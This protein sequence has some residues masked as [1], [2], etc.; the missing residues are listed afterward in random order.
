MK[1]MLFITAF[2]PNRRTAGQNYSKE[3]LSSLENNFEI[4]LISFSYPNH[5]IE[6]SSKINILKHYNVSKFSKLLSCFKIPLIHP[7]FATRFRY[8]LLV[9]I[10]KNKGSYNLIYFDFSQVFLYSL[11]LKNPFKIM[12]S[13]DVIYQ[14]MKRNKWFKLNPFN[15]LLYS[16]EKK[17]LRTGDLILTF[18]KKDKLLLTDLYDIRSDVVSFFIDEKIKQLK[19]DAL[20]FERKFC[21]FGAWN[22][23]ENKEGLIWFM[24]NVLPFVDATIK[25]EIIGPG[26][27]DIVMQKYKDY[28]IEYVG[29]IENPY[30]KIAESLA[31]IAPVFKGAGVKVKVIESLA[32]GTTVIGTNVAFEGIDDLGDGSMILCSAADDYIK[33][34][35][36]FS[37]DVR[38]KKI[39]TKSLFNIAYNNVNFYDLIKGL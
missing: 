11:F 32:T 26:L 39:R 34:I 24:N 27:D 7:F 6:V 14:K 37:L 22:R 21:F 13:H 25:F 23:P 19:Y 15:W 31:L 8:D 20:L 35:N 29:F 16:T 36:E 38:N 18:S 5:N 4:D 30:I 3:L 1:K 28:N 12:M 17:I 33:A 10:L 2:P 9:Y